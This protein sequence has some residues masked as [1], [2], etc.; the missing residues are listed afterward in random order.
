MGNK[1]NQTSVFTTDAN[2]EEA[3]TQAVINT[4]K[5]KEIPLT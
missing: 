4:A 2:V 5:E 1:D 3:K